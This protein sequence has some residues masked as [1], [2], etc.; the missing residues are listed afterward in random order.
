[1]GDGP[2]HQHGLPLRVALI[3]P[4]DHLRFAVILVMVAGEC[5]RGFGIRS[6]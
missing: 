4:G 5:T 2:L 1:M 6:A 3:G